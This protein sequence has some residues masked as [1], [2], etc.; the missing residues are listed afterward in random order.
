MAIP[1]EETVVVRKGAQPRDPTEITINCPDQVGLACDIARTIYEFGLSVT[2]GDFST[3]GRWCFLVFW[4]IPRV[5]VVK[6]TKWSLLK[7][8]LAAHCPPSE[9]T[10]IRPPSAEPKPQ[11]VHLLQICT[12]DRTGLLN[13]VT[14]T[15]WDMELTIQKVNVSTSPDGKAIDLFFLTDNRNELP[16]KSRKEQICHKLETLLSPGL[17]VLELGPVGPD[18]GANEGGVGI[19]TSIPYT[20]EHYLLK[21]GNGFL[22][23]DKGAEGIVSADKQ[24]HQATVT[25]DNN[26]SPAHSFVQ[27]V[28]RDRKGLVFDCLRTLKDILIKV[29][30]ARIATDEDGMCTIDMFIMGPDGM[31]IQDAQQVKEFCARLQNEVDRPMRIMVVTR[32]PDSELLVGTPMEASGRG[33]PR[34]LFDVTS[35]LSRLGLQVFK[36]DISRHEVGGRQWEVYRFIVQDK[37][38][39]PITRHRT[40]AFIADQ[41]REVL[42]G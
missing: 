29:A 16:A 4:V 31:K 27:V 40:R 5:R 11:E 37:Y 35:L 21:D 32:G 25:L 12:N 34:V 30:Y 23:E 8:R 41:V 3:D 28:A 14:Q 36:A 39:Q 19:S 6:P 26:M 1:S 17:T 7:Q 42:M 13:D 24:K 10:L 20:V 2:K 38:G 18:S 22:T 15:L 33:R 9:L